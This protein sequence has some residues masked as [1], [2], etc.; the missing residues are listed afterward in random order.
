MANLSAGQAK[1]DLVRKIIIV[2]KCVKGPVNVREKGTI[3]VRNKDLS[4]KLS[5]AA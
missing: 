4:P 5:T 1:K 3:N 2:S